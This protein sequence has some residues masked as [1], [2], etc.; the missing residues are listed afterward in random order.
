MFLKLREE[1]R[2]DFKK[3]MNETNKYSNGCIT[4]YEKVMVEAAPRQLQETGDLMQPLPWGCL[5]DK[6]M[7]NYCYQMYSQHSP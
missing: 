5:Q 2:I 4:K 7:P 3:S 1:D 6:L